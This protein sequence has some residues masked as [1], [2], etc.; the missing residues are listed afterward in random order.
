MSELGVRLRQAREAQGISLAQAAL[1]TRILQQSLT[2]LEEG[3]FERLPSDVV[4]RGFIRNYAQYLGLSDDDL[5]EVYRRERG[6][7]DRV[8]IVPATTS[9]GTRS[10]VLPN[11]LGIFFVTLILVGLA[12]VGLSATGRIG[13]RAVGPG[14]SFGSLT[15]PTDP[16]QPT[17]A[18]GATG[19]LPTAT[20]A[21]TATTTTAATAATEAGTAATADVNVTP[22]TA[23]VPSAA[24]TAVPAANT[25]TAVPAAN[26]VTA[27]A[28]ASTATAAAGATRPA[29]TATAT[30]RGTATTATASAPIVLVIEVPRTPGNQ[31]SWVRVTLDGLV[32]FEGSLASGD[33]KEFTAQRRVLIRAG[34]PAFVYVTVNGLKQGPLSNTNA[35]PVNWAWPPQ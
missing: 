6:A 35:Q 3:A 4:I 5:I 24:V 26:T 34:K 17:L 23:A 7:T 16:A 20:T 1:D 8:R 22:P 10:F 27:T 29:G 33:K 32:A 25:V 31:T 2:A 19:T 9:P 15:A 28:A 12:Y 30:I 14:F 18:P 21:A 13:L 11:F